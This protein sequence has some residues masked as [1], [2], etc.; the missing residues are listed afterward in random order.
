MIRATPINAKIIDT[1]SIP[2]IDSPKMK[3]EST[4]TH[5]GLVI[6]MQ[7][8]VATGKY[9]TPL[10]MPE[11]PQKPAKPLIRMIFLNYFGISM[12]SAPC[13]F[14]KAKFIKTM[15]NERQYKVSKG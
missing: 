15:R 9:L 3:Y 11:I 8:A 1:K 7:L 14:T 6:I 5:R 12:T 4:A 10:K 2:D 13:D